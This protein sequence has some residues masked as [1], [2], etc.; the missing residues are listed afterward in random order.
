MTESTW[1]KDPPDYE[2][3]PICDRVFEVED[4]SLRTK[5]HELDMTELEYHI[6]TVHRMVKLRRGSNYKWVDAAEMAK[7]VRDGSNASGKG[8]SR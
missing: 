6:R 4:V 7:L 3:C 5:G 2:Q 1:P 8:K